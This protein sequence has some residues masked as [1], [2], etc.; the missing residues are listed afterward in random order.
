V[1][2]SVETPGLNVAVADAT[3]PLPSS[4]AL[5]IWARQVENARQQTETAVTELSL[6]FGD[7][8]QK[9]DSSIAASQRESEAHAHQALLDSQQAE[10]N[11]SHVISALKEMQSSRDVLTAEMNSIVA[12]IAELQLMAEDVKTIAFRTNLLSI[13]A[14]IE[15]AHAGESGRGFGV[16]AHE[17]HVLSNESRS[18]V[19]KINERI[20]SI[21][22]TLRKIE[23][24][25]KSVSGHD[26]QAIRSSEQSIRTVLERQQQRV[27]GLASVA[28]SARKEHNAI[29]NDIEEALVKLQFQDRVSQI[30]TQVVSTMQQG[31]S[32][33]KAPAGHTLAEDL[34][35]ERLQ[36]M[37]S[38]Y[39]TDE[40]RRIHEGLEAETV[41]PREVTFF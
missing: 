41:A 34:E 37:A 33:P 14:A 15:A 32:S 31:G 23:G 17:V 10:L 38:S 27:A 20:G 30:L 19:Q 11:L 8:V 16:V 2:K 22:D 9:M 29:R 18:T 39:T 25:N 3:A 26:V 24:Y 35:R 5:A 21:T 28:N 12:Y 7:I 13:N 6:N 1:S 40:Q 4:G 36:Q